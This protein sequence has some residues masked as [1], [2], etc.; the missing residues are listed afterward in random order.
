MSLEEQR[1]KTEGK[2][3]SRL[4][5]GLRYIAKRLIS[6]II[7]FF[8]VILF[9]FFLFEAVPV[10]LN[11]NIGYFYLP[12]GFTK[13]QLNYSVALA[14]LSKRYGLDQPLSVRFVDY[15]RDIFTFGFGYSFHFE[16]PVTQLILDR[17]PVTA[18]IVIPSLIITTLMAI[19]M[20][21]VSANRRGKISDQVISNSAI[22]T[23]F[24]PAFWLGF[25]I[26]YVLTVQYNLFPSS[27]TLALLSKGNQTINLIKLL[28][29][30]IIT[31]SITTYGV[32]TVVMRNNSIEVLQQEFVNILRAKGLS[33][34]KI[35]YKHV[36]RNA[37]LPVFTRVGI[38]LAFLL[39][40]IVFIEDVFNVQGLGDLLLIAAQNF[41]IP[42]LLG[43]FYTID[44]FA[45][46]V[47]TLMDFLYV[48]IDPRVRYE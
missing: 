48:V 47:L 36:F 35:L 45:I 15:M 19:F 7:L 4:T 40:G 5:L 22:I 23:Y 25:I 42:L 9:N 43:D 17:L 11:V 44:L 14:G 6:R 20:G 16:Q 32:R 13:N 46:I 12:P 3:T 21:I 30:P 41:D 27:Y 18:E 34:S 33:N 24:I 26:W 28:I 1:G 31:L 37:F 10:L 39:S 2:L 8:A 29:P 38:D